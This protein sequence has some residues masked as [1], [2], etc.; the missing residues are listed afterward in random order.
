MNKS[1]DAVLRLKLESSLLEE[2]NKSSLIYLILKWI[3][4][5]LRQ[6]SLSH[7]LKRNVI[8]DLC[9][10]HKGRRNQLEVLLVGHLLLLLVGPVQR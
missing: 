2:T 3:L 9:R 6:L 8:L 4:K 5:L 10:D 7:L 1:K